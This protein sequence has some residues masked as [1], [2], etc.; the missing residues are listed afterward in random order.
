VTSLCVDDVATPRSLYPQLRNVSANKRRQVYWQCT[1]VFFT[2]SVRCNPEARH[3]LYTND[4]KATIWDGIDFCVFLIDLGINIKLLPFKLFR[5]LEHFL[6]EFRNAF[7]KLN[8]FFALS[9]PEAG[10]HSLLLNSDCVWTR[11]SPTLTQSIQSESLLLLDAEP[12]SLPDIKICSLNWRDIGDLYRELD[13]TY[14]VEAEAPLHFGGEIIGGSRVHLSEV[15]EQLRDAWEQIVKTYSLAPLRFCNQRN[16]FD[17][18]E[19]MTSFVCNHM[20]RLWTDAS[21]FI[22]HVWTSYQNKNVRFTDVQL[23][24]WH[25]PNEKIQGLPVLSRRVVDQNSHYWK[26]PLE[27]LAGYLGSYLRVLHPVWRLRRLLTLA[28]KLPRLLLIT[29]CLLQPST[30]ILLPDLV[31]FFSPHL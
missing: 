27:A 29:K 5:P 7:Y 1:A 17:G 4:D 20:P 13:L 22:R 30:L 25:L 14:L 11:P 3:L 21:P 6:T 8:A 16:I 26:L 9:Q 18:D 24:L 12:E 10:P 15:A 31:S 23:P 19:C 28:T 2:I